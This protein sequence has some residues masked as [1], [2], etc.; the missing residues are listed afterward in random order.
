MTEDAEL[1]RAYAHDRAENAFAELVSRHLN[2][3]YSAALRQVGGDTH[4]AEDV[5]QA[6]FAHR[7]ALY[8]DSTNSR[9]RRPQQA[10]PPEA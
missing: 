9:T 7:L 2:L 1:L 4:A 10:T 3:V 5:T 8:Y 6:V